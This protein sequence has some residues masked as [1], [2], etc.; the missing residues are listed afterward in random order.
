M[1]KSGAV[2]GLG[3]RARG[4]R[5]RRRRR[6]GSAY[7][8]APRAAEDVACSVPI[9]APIAAI[10]PPPRSNSAAS[11]HTEK[12][13]KYGFDGERAAV[14]SQARRLQFQGRLSL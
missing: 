2:R 7:D 4:R 6:R 14:E 3:W 9:P 5:R 1:I 11:L 8:Y 13:K 12:E 10:L